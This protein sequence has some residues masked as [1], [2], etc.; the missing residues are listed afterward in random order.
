MLKEASQE[1]FKHQMFFLESHDNL[2]F[3]IR[4]L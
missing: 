3:Y 2:V 1:G 4:D